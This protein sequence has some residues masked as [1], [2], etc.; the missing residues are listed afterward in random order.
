VIPTCGPEDD[1]ELG[2]IKPGSLAALIMNTPLWLIAI[3]VGVLLGM[4]INLVLAL[5]PEAPVG[6]RGAIG[7]VIT[8]HGYEPTREAAMGA[9][10]KSWR[11]G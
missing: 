3:I 4:A 6:K 11:R 10:A 2:T 1:R 9:F 5:A 8:A 7:H